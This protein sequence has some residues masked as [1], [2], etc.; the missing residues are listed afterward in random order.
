MW[1]Y[2]RNYAQILDLIF[3]HGKMQYI[4]RLEIVGVVHNSMKITNKILNI[5]RKVAENSFFLFYI[6]N[7]PSLK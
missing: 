4:C 5:Q 3:L 1:R 7:V 2:S 6:Y